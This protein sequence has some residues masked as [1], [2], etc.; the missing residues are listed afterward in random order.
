MGIDSNLF[1]RLVE[2]EHSRARAYCGRLAGGYDDGDDLYQESV[3]RAFG[4]FAELRQVDSFRPW[5]YRIISNTYKGRFRSP[6][7]RRI[8]SGSSDPEALAPGSDPTGLYEARR[9]LGYAF[10]ALSADDRVMVTLAELEGWTIAEL[11]EMMAKTEGFVKMRLLRARKK[12]RR[13]L[14]GLCR[15]SAKRANNQG[16]EKICCVTRPEED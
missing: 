9:R 14:S 13:R 8:L 7:W 10:G 3:I 16:T 1:W 11:A 4:G 15:E 12:M 2:E 5:L 6:W